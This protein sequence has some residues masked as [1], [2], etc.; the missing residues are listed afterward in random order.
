MKLI[1]LHRPPYSRPVSAQPSREAGSGGTLELGFDILQ[2]TRVVQPHDLELLLGQH[3]SIGGFAVADLAL[4]SS[5]RSALVSVPHGPP[6][7]YVA[8]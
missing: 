5:Q 3:L 1:R 6:A 7:L 8:V 2:I 4:E